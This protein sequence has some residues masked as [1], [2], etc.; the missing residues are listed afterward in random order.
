MQLSLLATAAAAADAS[1]AVADL[2]L[3]M[4][5]TGRDDAEKRACSEG[6]LVD[7]T[8]SKVWGGDATTG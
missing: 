8:G 3:V 7:K 5:A 4:A 6:V 2:V 1:Y